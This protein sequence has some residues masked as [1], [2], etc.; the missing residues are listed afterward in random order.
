[1]CELLIRVRD[2][3][4]EDD[5]YLDA[6]CLKRGDVVVVVEDGWQ[7]GRQELSNP[8]WRILQL[9]NVS[10]MQAQAFLG[11]EVNDD[12]AQPSRVLRRRGWAFGLG[13][14]PAAL[15]AWIDDDSRKTPTR[16]VNLTA[17]QILAMRQRKQRLTDPN[18]IG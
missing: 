17:A 15:R 13:S 4:N 18:V 8:D 3:V 16:R 7:W 11:Q 10:V 14:L 9:P 12:P 1:M 5:P 2:K 6:Q